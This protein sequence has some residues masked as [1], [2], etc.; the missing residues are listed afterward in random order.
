MTVTLMKMKI[1]ERLLSMK[2][3]VIRIMTLIMMI[4]SL[5]LLLKKIMFLEVVME[6]PSANQS[7][8]T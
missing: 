8:T 6:G 3:I 1:Q 2:T 5:Q 4:L 7:D